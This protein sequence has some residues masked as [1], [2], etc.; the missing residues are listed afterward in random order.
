MMM[1]MIDDDDDDDDISILWGL[2]LMM[3]VSASN[4]ETSFRSLL[5]SC[6]RPSTRQSPLSEMVVGG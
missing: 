4:D 3:F 6:P 1:M 5:L 2:G